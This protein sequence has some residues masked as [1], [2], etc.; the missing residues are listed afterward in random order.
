VPLL[1]KF[2]DIL[3]RKGGL[4][5]PCLS[6]PPPQDGVS[7]ISPLP[8]SVNY[9][10]PV[11]ITKPEC[12]FAAGDQPE[13]EDFRQLCKAFNLQQALAFRRILDNFMLQHPRIGVMNVDG[14]QP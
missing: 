3:V 2:A 4:E 8:H 1:K 7:A 11:S 9:C 14:V 5:P 13:L 10:P 6:A 12:E